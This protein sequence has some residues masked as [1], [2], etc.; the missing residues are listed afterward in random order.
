MARQTKRGVAARLFRSSG[1]AL[2]VLAAA[3]FAAAPASAN[4][5]SELNSFFDDMGAA[6]NATGPVA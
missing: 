6:A 2:A 1:T 4:V 5:G 3:S